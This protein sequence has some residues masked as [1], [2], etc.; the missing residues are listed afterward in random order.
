[1]TK[2]SKSLFKKFNFN[3]KVP[4]DKPKTGGFSLGSA[5]ASIKTEAL[6]TQPAK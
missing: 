6:K 3:P 1:M 2:L 4:S 5:L